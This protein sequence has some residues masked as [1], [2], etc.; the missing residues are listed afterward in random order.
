MRLQAL[1]LTAALTALAIPLSAGAQPVQVSRQTAATEQ[2]M[3]ARSV[4]PPGWIWE[5]AGYVSFGRWEDAHC[6][7]RDYQQNW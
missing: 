4:C 2:A 7:L 6:A 3:P 1:C 5:P